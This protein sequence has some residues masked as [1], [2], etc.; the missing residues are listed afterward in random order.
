MANAG[1][2]AV[3]GDGAAARITKGHL[4]GLAQPGS[5]YRESEADCDVRAEKPPAN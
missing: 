2:R 3:E 4:V 5:P 1:A